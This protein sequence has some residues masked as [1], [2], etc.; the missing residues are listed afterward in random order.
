[1]PLLHVKTFAVYMQEIQY[2][3]TSLCSMSDLEHFTSEWAW[4]LL[5]MFV[6]YLQLMFVRKLTNIQAC[7]I[8][9]LKKG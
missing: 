2:F 5:Y 1:M 6:P 4:L 7:G 9:F 8:I 3:I